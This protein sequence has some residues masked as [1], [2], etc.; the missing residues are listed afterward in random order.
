MDRGLKPCLEAVHIVQDILA[1]HPDTGQKLYEE[2]IWTFVLDKMAWAELYAVPDKESI[3]SIDVFVHPNYRGHD[4]GKLCVK[5]CI[6]WAQDNGVYC[7]EWYVRAR[8]KASIYLAQSC[9]FTIVPY[10]SN[11]LWTTLALRL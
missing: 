3:V 6:D 1:E 7:I 5:K 11:H 10:M 2:T 9:G 4:L 8:N